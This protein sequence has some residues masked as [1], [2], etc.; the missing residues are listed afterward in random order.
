[1]K[2][3]DIVDIDNNKLGEILIFELD[4]VDSVISRISRLLSIPPKFLYVTNEIT[5]NSSLEKIQILDIY[6]LLKTKISFFDSIITLFENNY[7][8][9]QDSFL[10]FKLFIKVFTINNKEL[11]NALEKELAQQN[12]EFY[13]ENMYTVSILSKIYY[14]FLQHLMVL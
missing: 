4:S 9:T 7:F 5:L 1:M 6:T 3:I 11:L 13:A 2:N 12:E 14:H 10:S 8:K